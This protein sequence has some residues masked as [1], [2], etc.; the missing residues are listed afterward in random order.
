MDP[1]E[2]ITKATALLHLT[3]SY[4][5]LKLMKRV[6]EK[7]KPL[8]TTDPG[9]AKNLHTQIPLLFEPMDEAERITK[10]NNLLDLDVYI[11]KSIKELLYDLRNVPF[12]A[13]NFNTSFKDAISKGNEQTRGIKRVLRHMR[14]SKDFLK[15]MN[16]VYDKIKPLRET[17]PDIAENFDTQ[18]RLLF[19]PM[20]EAERI[21]KSELLLDLDVELF[22]SIKTLLDELSDVPLAQKFNTSFEDAIEIGKAKMTGIR[23]SLFELSRGVRISPGQRG[24]T[25]TERGV[26]IS[27]GQ[28]RP[29]PTES[30][31]LSRGGSRS[32]T[33]LVRRHQ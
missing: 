32:T 23:R 3:Q 21:R 17:D 8:L 12:V 19:E 16:Q 25:P 2:K 24:P 27:P 30:D 22:K 33:S 11:F 20:D 29:T 13:Q 28:R 9:I 18:I 1:E 26:R 6:Y 31:L 7:I 5:F 4:N 10:L 14:Q 15:L